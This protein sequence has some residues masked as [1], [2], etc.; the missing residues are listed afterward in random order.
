MEKIIFCY[1]KLYVWDQLRTLSQLTGLP[2]FDDQ[3][4]AE[5]IEEDEYEDEDEYF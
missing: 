2:I 4:L 3:L 1:L 5:T